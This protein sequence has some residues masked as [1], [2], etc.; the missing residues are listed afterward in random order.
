MER[1]T[2]DCVQCS[3]SASTYHQ[4][5]LCSTVIRSGKGWVSGENQKSHLDPT[6]NGPQPLPMSTPSRNS[7][8]PTFGW[9]RAIF[10]FKSTVAGV[11]S[12]LTTVIKGPGR[13]YLFLADARGVVR[14]HWGGY[15]P[16][17][18]D[19]LLNAA[20]LTE[21]QT[22][23][24]DDLSHLRARIEEIFGFLKKRFHYLSHPFAEHVD[25]LDALVKFS[26]GVRNCFLTK[27]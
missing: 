27:S 22:N 15:S 2:L 3:M 1:G 9:I 12:N 20:V 18:F 16:K 10:L 17:I 8:E 5:H 19:V 23:H 6:L 25:E 7:K 26:I 14:K 21:E 4:S 11:Q 24:N 13:R